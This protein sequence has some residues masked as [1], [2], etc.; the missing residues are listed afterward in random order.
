VQLLLIP[1][2]HSSY[3]PTDYRTLLFRASTQIGIK[4]K[5]CQ[6]Y[7]HQSSH[8]SGRSSH[9]ISLLNCSRS[10]KFPTECAPIHFEPCPF[11]AS[12]LDSR[13]NLVLPLSL[14]RISGQSYVSA[15]LRVLWQPRIP[16]ISSI[17]SSNGDI[18][19]GFQNSACLIMI[20]VMLGIL[21]MKVRTM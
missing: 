20:V 10:S 12:H 11:L 6:T 2:L 4:Q 5:H 15:F 21:A 3:L 18:K 9:R 19:L 13:I 14:G 7:C 16:F 8:Y 1:A 17:A